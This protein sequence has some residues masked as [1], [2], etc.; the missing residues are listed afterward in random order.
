MSARRITL[1]GLGR[2]LN[3]AAQPLY[4]LDDELG[5]VFMNRACEQWL[6]PGAAELLGQRCAYHSSA[7]GGETAARAAGL[8]PPPEVLTGQIATGSVVAVGADGTRRFRHARFLPLGS[9][10]ADVIGVVAVVDEQDMPTPPEPLPILPEAEDAS[11]LHEHVQWF[12]QEIA[13]RYRGDWLIGRSVAIRRVRRQV[14]LAIGSRVS[15]LVVGPRGSGRQLVA[16]AIHYGADPLA[17]GPLVPLA[18]PVL[19]AE[20]LHATVAALASGKVGEESA[21]RATLLLTEADK[22][23][24]EAQVV[25]AEMFVGRPF[26]PR[27][28]ATAEQPLAELVRRG[29]FRADLAAALSTLVIELPPL[30]ERREDIPLLA[31][32]FLEEA[33]ARGSKQV[34]RFTPEA[35]EQLDAYHWPGNVDE[36][37]KVV[38]ESH[39]RTSGVEIAPLDLP[40]RLQ[41]ATVAAAHPRREEQRIVLGK[42]LGEMERELIRRA[43][44]KAKGNK[45]K[46]AR[47]LGLSRPRLYRR[48]VQLGLD[49]PSP[50]S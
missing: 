41:V 40:E 32:L 6:G 19:G 18:C 1:A 46:A 11:T 4:V 8:C 15:V 16:T 9:S 34:S 23:P 12:R 2:L 45:A 35:L 48:M 29:A 10:P 42:F 49:P 27:L 43:L 28:I 24:P 22:L 47:L 26:A 25:L 31:Q 39:Q 13:G 3:A 20:L 5:I 50:A 7:T 44:V 33:N 36:L 38:E 37:A 17:A 21:S 30:A 14:E